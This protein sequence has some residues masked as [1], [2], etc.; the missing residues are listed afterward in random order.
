MYTSHRG[1]RSKGSFHKKFGGKQRFNDRGF[2]R[3]SF[4]KPSFKATCAE[5]G[6]ACTVPFRP[7]GSKPVLC[8]NCFKGGD[9]AKS[10]GRPN[11]S[12][13]APRERSY[14]APGASN[15]EEQ[16]RS[17]NKKLDTI[18]TALEALELD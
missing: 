12:D 16:L 2:D 11:F 17:I 8:S 13:R 3:P 5:C 10:F 4:D 18:I 9:G 15:I 7:N 1:D 6:D 14:S